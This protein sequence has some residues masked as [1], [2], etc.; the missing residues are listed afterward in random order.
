MRTEAEIKKF[1]IRCNKARGFGM[2]E[3]RCPA[4]N[5]RRKGCCAECSMPS[6]LTW[7]LGKETKPS[8][9]GQD[10]LIEVFRN[11]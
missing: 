7:V 5:G 10:F 1:L 9:N 6:S 4:E 3:K 8:A 2:S 11:I